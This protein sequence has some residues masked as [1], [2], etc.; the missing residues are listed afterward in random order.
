MSK[1]SVSTEKRR[2]RREVIFIL[3]AVVLI[4][5]STVIETRMLSLPSISLSSRIIIYG[6]INITVILF[7]LMFFLVLRN[8]IKLFLDRRKNVIG[9]RLRAKLVALFVIVSLIPSAFMFIVIIATG[10]VANTINKWYIPRMEKSMS[11]TI[12][13]ARYYHKNKKF[14]PD[15]KKIDDMIKSI[16]HFYTA[17]SQIKFIKNPIETTYLIVFSTLTLLI[18][19]ISSWIGFYLSKKITKPVTD[20]VDG[21]EKVAEGELDIEIPVSSDDEIG[22]LV[23]SFNNMAKDLGKNKKVI[24]KV[25]SDLKKIN[26]EIERRRKYMEI[27][28]KNIQAGVVAVDSSGKIRS[29]NYAVQQ[30]FQLSPQEVLNKN[31]KDV[32]DK[33]A[34]SEIRDI[35]KDLAKE[36][37]ESITKEIKLNVKG[38]LNVYIISITVMKDE[39]NNYIGFIIV[40]NDTTDMMKA[41]RMAAWEDVAKRIAHEIKN[42][43]TPIKLSAQR[44]KRK[45]EGKIGAD[46]R[47][48]NDSIDTIIKEVN[49]LKGLVDEFSL[50]ARLPKANFDYVNINLLLSESLTLYKNAHKDIKFIEVFDKEMPLLYI[51]KLQVKRAF[52]NIFNNAVY[53]IHT[54]Q[55][56]GKSKNKNEITVIT[57]FDKDKETAVIK[58]S[59]T[60][61]GIDAEVIQNIFEPY[62][63]TKKGGAGLGLA[64]TKN[65]ITENN[66]WITAENNDQGG[67]V[68]IIGYRRIETQA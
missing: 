49:D 36:N 13:V 43:L 4:L 33:T 66:G 15:N 5:V 38:K 56:K 23:S 48:F 61:A 41:Q 45:F 53:S 51:D 60:G 64:I 29:I 30:M 34:F 52:V 31:Y 1:K 59:D 40:L 21:T 62:F 50:Y 65:I 47:I 18:L 63:S 9:S 3:I 8:I 17:Y 46:S 12:K 39:L 24:E 28:L 68:F 19:F 20:L 16:S 14:M 57:T 10:F 54:K 7:L 67:A 2:I 44:L 22:M 11:Y 42:P 35:V 25:N 58:I 6:Y 32:F 26:E 27:I 37:K 55:K